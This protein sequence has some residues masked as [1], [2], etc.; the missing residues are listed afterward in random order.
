MAA[1]TAIRQA[2]APTI[3]REPKPARA[4]RLRNI[5]AFIAP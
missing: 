3:A 5:G 4:P 1:Q 2:V